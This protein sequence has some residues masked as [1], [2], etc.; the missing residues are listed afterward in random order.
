MLELVY[1]S[2]FSDLT[3][4]FIERREA[5]RGAGPLAFADPTRVIVPTVEMGKFLELELARRRGSAAQF[6]Y[7]SIQAAFDRLLLDEDDVERTQQLLRRR[8]LQVL[9]LELLSTEALDAHAESGAFDPVRRYL[10]APSSE[11]RDTRRHQLAGQIAALFEEYSMS[12]PEMLSAWLHGKSHFTGRHG[13]TEAWQS[14]LWRELCDDEGVIRVADGSERL[15]LPVALERARRAGFPNIDDER[16]YHFFGFSTFGPSYRAV[17]S[18]LREVASVHVYLCSAHRSEAARHRLVER[19]GRVG[20]VG[21]REI[22]A[23]AGSNVVELPIGVEEAGSGLLGELRSD[24]VSGTNHAQER[25]DAS[26]QLLACPSLDREVEIVANEI[27]HLVLEE[28]AIFSD[29]A[30]AVPEAQYDVYRAQIEAAFENFERLP[31]KFSSHIINDESRVLEAFELLMKLPFGDFERS[32]MLSLVCHPNVR[33]AFR[34]ADADQWRAW[35]I[36]VGIFHGADSDDH[37]ETYI[38]RDIFNWSQGMRRLLLGSYLAPN[39]DTIEVDGQDY[40]PESVGQAGVN[41]AAALYTL[42]ESLVADARWL[43]EQ[44]L[45]L[46]EW[47]DVLVGLVETY[48]HPSD[49]EDLDYAEEK[50]Q[51]TI[52]RRSLE[53]LAETPCL[54][55][56]QR[57]S[58]RAIYHLATDSVG[59]VEMPGTKRFVGGVVV[60]Q[61]SAL[62]LLPFEHVFVVGLA[63]GEYP[64]V[65]SE[66]ELDLRRAAPRDDDVTASERDRNQ[67]LELVMAPKQRLYL[68][69]V[70]RDPITG[71]PV[72]AS[73]LVN[74][75]RRS[76]DGGDG[77][78]GGSM[79]RVHPL[80]RYDRHSDYFDYV[81]LPRDQGAL[82]AGVETTS[83]LGPNLHGEA[84][85]EAKAQALREALGSSMAS[86]AGSDAGRLRK[87]LEQSPGEAELRRLASLHLLP[88]STRPGSALDPRE[89]EPEADQPSRPRRLRHSA[90]YNFLK[91]PFQTAAKYHLGIYDVD[92]DESRISEERFASDRMKDAVIPRNVMKNA[93]AMPSAGLSDADFERLYDEELREDRARGQWVEE[94]FYEVIKAKHLRVLRAWRDN[95]R[96]GASYSPMLGQDQVLQSALF[97]DRPQ[98]DHVGSLVIDVREDPRRHDSPIATRV[99]LHGE[100][101]AM[102]A[103]Q[104]WFVRAINKDANK[105]ETRFRESLQP[106]IEH[107]MLCALGEV[108][109]RHI[110][111]LFAK[112]FKSPSKA[113]TQTL[114]AVSQADALETLEMMLC[115][116]LVRTHAYLL[117]HDVVYDW[118]N[119]RPEPRPFDEMLEESLN[120]FFP[121]Y[122]SYGPIHDYARYGGPGRHAADVIERRYRHHPFFEGKAI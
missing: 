79:V 46:K 53:A 102:C 8:D 98:P 23:L 38:E 58:Y 83:E 62:R 59:E 65:D 90:L 81:G 87:W 33:A 47:A 25:R 92:D 71:D 43:R 29:I 89:V 64:A 61:P 18:A 77:S 27:W 57:Y 36:D 35:A 9:L 42:V 106:Y 107:L 114:P 115:S 66:N 13:R 30:V 84:L 31:K 116:L 32:E 37:D 74:E 44:S 121:P 88:R 60:A 55:P 103:R 24:L 20:E 108:R 26:L 86:W 63:E 80:R 51:L 67:F 122:C 100:T 12:R 52:L 110:W 95:L 6:S 54:D 101:Y 41:S 94:P 5:T 97:G 2:R 16:D 111:F 104:E 34:D 113:R 118:L 91:T 3:D 19:L 93:L 96:H 48:V 56:A 112:G 73:S 10:E 117:P 4:A 21:L 1:G 7:E 105:A 15:T 120:G 99:E 72:P 45:T 40:W 28:G 85:A 119:A 68:S 22:E 75:L 69:W 17:L 109:D 49:L 14:A 76:L 70:A 39:D 82:G 50:S 78:D 11:Q